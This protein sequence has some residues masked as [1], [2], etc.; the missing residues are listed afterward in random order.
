MINVI[1]WI[2]ISHRAIPPVTRS[3][4]RLS[5][6]LRLI[7]S[8]SAFIPTYIP[9]HT[10][11]PLFLETFVRTFFLLQDRVDISTLCAR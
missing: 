7:L 10:V 2:W 6:L 1:L 11:H 4:S 5:W 3:P 8:L 9:S